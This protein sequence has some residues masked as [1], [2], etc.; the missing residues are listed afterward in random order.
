M[1]RS[2]S[3]IRRFRRTLLFIEITLGTYRYCLIAFTNATLVLS[4]T[5]FLLMTILVID[6]AIM[7]VYE[8]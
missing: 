1:R 7:V 4:E 2:L 3:N 5:L 8:L 6:D